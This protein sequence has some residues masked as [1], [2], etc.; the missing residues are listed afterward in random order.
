M[1]MLTS[2]RVSISREWL[3]IGSS[4]FE[5]LIYGILEGESRGFG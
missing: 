3:K 2:V 4:A 5:V 1:A